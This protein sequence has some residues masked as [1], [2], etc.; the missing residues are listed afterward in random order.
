MLSI[1]DLWATNCFWTAFTRGNIPVLKER[2]RIAVGEGYVRE[3]LDE[4]I[5][6]CEVEFNYEED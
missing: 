4:I 1:S 3:I 5:R 2:F 6:Q